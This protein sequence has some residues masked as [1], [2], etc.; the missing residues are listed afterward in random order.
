MMT[1][2]KSKA[3]DF[4]KKYKFYNTDLKRLR[5]II[6]SQGYMIIEFNDIGNDKDVEKVICG[7]NLCDQVKYAKAFTYVNESLRL[8]FVHEGLSDEEKLMVLLHEE[9]HIFC[10]HTDKKSV[11]GE[12]V[13]QENEANEFAHFVAN[14]SVLEK[15]TANKRLVI[16]IVVFAVALAVA[17]CCVVSV[18]NAGIYYEDYYVTQTGDKYHVKNC[19]YIEGNKKVQRLK[20]EDFE[21]GRYEPCLVCVGK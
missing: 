3:R 1:N 10:G 4:V 16:G 20:R 9:G 19:R 6:T 12:D 8:V 2:A 13:L 11:I 14:K 21:N 7:L 5:E 18:R 17:I 15:I